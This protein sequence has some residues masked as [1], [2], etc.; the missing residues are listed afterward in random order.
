MIGP[1]RCDRPGIRGKRSHPA[2]K[3]LAADGVGSHLS[4]SIGQGLRVSREAR[5]IGSPHEWALLAVQL[6]QFQ[7]IAEMGSLI[8]MGVAGCG[9]GGVVTDIGRA[10][11]VGVVG[12]AAAMAAWSEPPCQDLVRTKSCSMLT[13]LT[14]TRTLV[15]DLVVVARDELILCPGPARARS[16]RKP[17]S[18]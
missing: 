7:V 8:T 16:R 14:V 15:D 5:P 18:G 4:E 9:A 6:D 13:L 2:S 3:P 12:C 17:R 11:G 10:T 1:V